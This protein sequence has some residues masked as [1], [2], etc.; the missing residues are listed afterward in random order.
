MEDGLIAQNEILAIAFV[1]GEIIERSI[2]NAEF[3]FGDL[4]FNGFLFV[5]FVLF[6]RNV[7]CDEK[8]ELVQFV[9]LSGNVS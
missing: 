4:L 3:I 6:L 5:V 9:K 2:I 1:L 7:G 8:L